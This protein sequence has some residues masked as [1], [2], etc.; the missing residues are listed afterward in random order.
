MHSI[1]EADPTPRDEPVASLMELSKLVTA[2]VAHSLAVIDSSITVPQLRVLVLVGAR[3]PANVAAVAAALGVSPS[4]ASRTCDRLVSGELLDRREAAADRRNV[5]LTLTP[6]GEE[7]TEGLLANRRLFFETVVSEMGLA[8][9]R[10]LTQAL[11]SFTEAVGRADASG[12][13]GVDESN[14]LQWLV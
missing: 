3:G 4:N 11:A 8:D 6:E 14:L 7:L 1:S 13:L 5:E 9:K 12:P 2:V 10:R